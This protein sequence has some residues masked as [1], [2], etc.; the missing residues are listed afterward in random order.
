MKLGTVSAAR[1]QVPTSG[2]GCPSRDQRG[3]ARPGGSL[4]DIGA[5]ESQPPVAPGGIVASANPNQGAF[6]LSWTA[7]SDLDL[8]SVSY[9]LESRDADDPDWSVSRTGIGGASTGFS[10]FAPEREGR[11][12]YRLF[13]SDGAFRTDTAARARSSSTGRRHRARE[14]RAHLLVGAAQLSSGSDVYTYSWVTS[15]AWKGTCRQFI[16]KLA[17]GTFHLANVRFK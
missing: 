1:D 2:A 6:S 17:D 11:I 4:C 15:K 13:A 5:V 10:S 16:L 7:A 12:H 14:W 8:D 9:I 3:F